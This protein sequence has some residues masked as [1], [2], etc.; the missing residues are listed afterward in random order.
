MLSFAQMRREV[1]S[2]LFRAALDYKT[3]MSPF[4]KALCIGGH[5]LNARAPTAMLLHYTIDSHT[6][7]DLGVF[8]R[9][10]FAP[11]QPYLTHTQKTRI[12]GPAHAKVRF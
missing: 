1:I 10:F 5:N 9:A 6:L 2:S 8:S 3:A 7:C 4:A 11:N 12:H